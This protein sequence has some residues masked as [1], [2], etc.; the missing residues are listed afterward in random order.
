[1]EKKNKKIRNAILLLS[2]YFVVLF[3]AKT[4]RSDDTAPI[5]YNPI[6]TEQT[7]EPFANY[8]KGDIY[9]GSEAVIEEIIRDT[10]DVY[11]IDDRGG[12]DPNMCICNSYKINDPRDQE[13]IV[14]ILLDYEEQDPT[15]WE[16][17][18]DSLLNEWQIH[19]L[20]YHL[21]IQK[22]SSINADLDNHDEDNFDS[23]I[24]TKILR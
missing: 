8:G 5:P 24:L 18:R 9:I 2:S 15:K 10:D 16:R 17:S 1:M 4:T 12:K 19:N 3:T 21:G 13:A 7:I 14:D 11:V 22:R 23:D 6:D 20:C